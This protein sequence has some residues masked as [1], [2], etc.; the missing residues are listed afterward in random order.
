MFRRKWRACVDFAVLP[1]MLFLAW[2]SG[3]RLCLFIGICRYW[4]A[5]HPARHRGPVK[6]GLPSWAATASST[7]IGKKSRLILRF[8]GSIGEY[9][10]KLLCD[11]HLRPDFL[12]FRH[13][14]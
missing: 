4:L 13:L 9:H 5:Q 6:L 10:P 1:L 12:R 2:G 11:R 3:W 7:R 8:G 14:L